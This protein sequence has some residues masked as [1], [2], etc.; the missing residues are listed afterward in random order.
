[1]LYLNW[2]PLHVLRSLPRTG[3]TAEILTLTENTVAY[4]LLSTSRRYSSRSLSYLL[5]VVLFAF[6]C[7][8]ALHNVSGKRSVLYAW[9]YC[10]RNQCYLWCDIREKVGNVWTCLKDKPRAP[11]WPRCHREEGQMRAVSQNNFAIT[12]NS[13]KEK[14]SGL[15]IKEMQR[16]VWSGKG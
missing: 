5:L 16:S 13:G 3:K 2:L 1:M 14:F 4:C 10:S 15:V 6:L 7:L 12:H 11:P 8:G 9:Y